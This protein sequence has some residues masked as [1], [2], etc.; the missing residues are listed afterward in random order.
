LFII[1][2][3]ICREKGRKKGGVNVELGDSCVWRAWGHMGIWRKKRETK[4]RGRRRKSASWHIDEEQRREKGRKHGAQH[5]PQAW[6]GSWRKKK[7]KEEKESISPTG[8]QAWGGRGRERKGGKWA[9]MKCNVYY[10][11]LL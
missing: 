11:P 5:I 6:L 4:K 2:A 8:Q 3:M 9:S 10:Y 7:G 1:V